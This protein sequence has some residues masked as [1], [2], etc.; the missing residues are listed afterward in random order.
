MDFCSFE[1]ENNLGKEG[2][3]LTS[4]CWRSVDGTVKSDV[5]KMKDFGFILHNGLDS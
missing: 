3:E 1:Q 5:V 4:S 2:L